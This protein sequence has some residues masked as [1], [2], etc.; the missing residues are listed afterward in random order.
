MNYLEKKID[1]LQRTVESIVAERDELYKKIDVLDN[2]IVSIEGALFVLLEAN[3]K[4]LF[5][6][7]AEQ[8]K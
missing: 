5:S 4:G 8:E 3:K 1:S 6:D 7:Y 2:Q